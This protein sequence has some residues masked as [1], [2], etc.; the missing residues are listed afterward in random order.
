MIKLLLKKYI[1]HVS[2]RNIMKKLFSLLLVTSVLFGAGCGNKKKNK[3]AQ[4]QKET[5]AQN[6][7]EQER[8]AKED[9][10]IVA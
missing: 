9:Y 7:V 10:S 2:L 4:Q 1:P 8:A 5:V 6:F 3:A